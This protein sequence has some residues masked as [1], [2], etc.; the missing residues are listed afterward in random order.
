MTKW[1]DQDEELLG[2]LREDPAHQATWEAFMVLL[3]IRHFVTAEVRGRIVL[4]GGAMGVWFGMVRFCARE[5]NEIAKEVA[6]HL[7]PLGHELEGVHI[8]SEMNMLC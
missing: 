5:I 6:M 1:T 7:A 4:V 3:A 2:T 8:W